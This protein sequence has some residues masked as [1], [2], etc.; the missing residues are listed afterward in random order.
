MQDGK[1]VEFDEP[2]KL[3]ERGGVFEGMVEQSGEVVKLREIISGEGGGAEDRK[4]KAKV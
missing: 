2:R 4:E 1:A 3:L